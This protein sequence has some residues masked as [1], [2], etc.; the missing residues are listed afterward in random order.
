MALLKQKDELISEYDRGILNGA[1]YVLAIFEWREPRYLRD[2]HATE[3]A[4]IL[5]KGEGE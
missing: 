3:A 5:S 1:E 4:E 2:T